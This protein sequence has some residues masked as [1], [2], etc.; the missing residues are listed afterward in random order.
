MKKFFDKSFLRR[1]PR[2]NDC[3]TCIHGTRFVDKIHDGYKCDIAAVGQCLHPREPYSGY[4]PREWIT[5][6]EMTI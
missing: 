3:S 5:L 4:E 6:E 2:Q 1:H